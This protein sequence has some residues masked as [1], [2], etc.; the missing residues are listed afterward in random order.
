VFGIG[1]FPPGTE[2]SANGAKR[3]QAAGRRGPNYEWTR[4]QFLAELAGLSP[5]QLADEKLMTALNDKHDTVN[6]GDVPARG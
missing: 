3:K 5:A 6:L 2:R 4:A 1:D